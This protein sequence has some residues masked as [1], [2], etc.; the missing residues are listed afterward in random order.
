MEADENLVCY[1]LTDDAFDVLTREHSG[2]AIKLLTN[3]ARELS[4]RLR[5]ATRMIYE[6][7]G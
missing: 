3:L 5:R 4:H 2:I 1:V 6:L 7:E